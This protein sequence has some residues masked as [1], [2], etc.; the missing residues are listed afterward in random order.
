MAKLW[1]A[2]YVRGRAQMPR[3]AALSLLG[4]S[5]LAYDRY[6][7]GER[8]GP[9]ALAGALTI[10]IVP[11]TLL[12]MMPTNNALLGVASGTGG[13]VLSE[14]AVRSLLLRWK[15]LN[16]MRSMFPLAGSLLGLWALL[17]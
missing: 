7:R 6:A 12:V 2:L 16:L 14:D 13:Q 15:N 5:Y 9:F 11:F 10:G 4:Y 17:A 1:E 3:F 8:W